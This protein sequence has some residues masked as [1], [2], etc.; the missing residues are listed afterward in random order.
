MNSHFMFNF[1]DNLETKL[2]SM[3]DS[4]TKNNIFFFD[5]FNIDSPMHRLEKKNFDFIVTFQTLNGDLTSIT[6]RKG[7]IPLYRNHEE[8]IPDI[9]Y[10][11]TPNENLTGIIVGDGQKFDKKVIRR[12]VLGFKDKYR[13]EL[14]LFEQYLLKEDLK[15]SEKKYF[16]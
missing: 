6:Y 9:E 14:N 4:Q 16:S 10:S 12:V 13:R 5:S 1:D 8:F 7:M 11:Y 2:V 15:P 3:N